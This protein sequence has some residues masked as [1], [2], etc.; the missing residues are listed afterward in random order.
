[1][2]A[3]LAGRFRVTCPSLT[4]RVRRA[5]IQNIHKH[6]AIPEGYTILGS[7]AAVTH[8]GHAE[9]PR[10]EIAVVQGGDNPAATVAAEKSVHVGLRIPIVTP[11]LSVIAAVECGILVSDSD[12]LLYVTEGNCGINSA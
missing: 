10:G 7:D 2:P 8:D 12:K 1:M 5:G 9:A 6:C 4:V 11:H 3:I